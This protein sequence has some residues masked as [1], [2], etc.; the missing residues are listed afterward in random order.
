MTSPTFDAVADVLVREFHAAQDKVK[1]ET[2]LQ[3]LGLD[4]LTLMEFVFAIEDL[5]ELRIPEDRLDPRQSGLTLAD[6]CAALDEAT[7]RSRPLSA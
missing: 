4:S 5:F 7:A 6:L 1:P 2:S 3:A